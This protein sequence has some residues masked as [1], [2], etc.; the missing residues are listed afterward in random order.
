MLPMMSRLYRNNGSIM[1]RIY[2]ASVNNVSCVDILK[3]HRFA[4]QYTGEDL[5]I[6]D[7]FKLVQPWNPCQLAQRASTWA[8]LTNKW[9]AGA[10]RFRPRTFC[11]GT[12]RHRQAGGAAAQNRAISFCTGSGASVGCWRVL[13]I[14]RTGN[15]KMPRAI[16]I[17]QGQGQRS[18]GAPLLRAGF[19]PW[20]LQWLHLHRRQT[21]RHH[22]QQR[23]SSKV[24]YGGPGRDRLSCPQHQGT[25]S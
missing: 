16:V 4:R 18:K 10:R 1:M 6:Q 14:E 24:I 3:T 2:G 12:G 15:G 5:S 11:A 21:K 17:P 13:L 19:R 20:S 7:S 22:R 9:R 8:A 23:I 25:P